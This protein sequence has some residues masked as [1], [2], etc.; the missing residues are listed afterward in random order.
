MDF[1]T[2]MKET[3]KWSNSKCSYEKK[4]GHEGSDGGHQFSAT[5]ALSAK[6]LSGEGHEEVVE[7]W[8]SWT[9]GFY[10]WVSSNTRFKS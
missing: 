5:Q 1:S 9:E 3:D 10:S 6:V 4:A 8:A 2:L 7:M